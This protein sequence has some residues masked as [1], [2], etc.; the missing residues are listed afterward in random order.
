MTVDF[1]KSLADDDD[2]DED[3]F[4]VEKVTSSNI[5][6]VIATPGACLEAARL[7]RL[8]FRYQHA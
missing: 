2:S 6:D 8:A 5:D 4:K 1:K 7:P 3:T